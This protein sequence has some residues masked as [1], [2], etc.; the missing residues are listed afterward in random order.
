MNVI[1]II[2]AFTLMMSVCYADDTLYCVQVARCVKLE[3]A[4]SV[5]NGLKKYKNK[6]IEKVKGVYEVTVGTYRVKESALPL[7]KQLKAIYS[8]A[9]IRPYA[10]ANPGTVQTKKITGQEE[11]KPALIPPAPITKE[12][13]NPK[14]QSSTVPASANKQEIQKIAPPELEN[15]FKKG[16]QNFRNQQYGPA[17]GLLSQYVS[18]SPGSKQCSAALFAMAKSLEAMG[19][20]LS[21]LGTFGRILDQYPQSPEAILSIIFMADIAVA[22][23]GLHYPVFKGGS[24]YVQDP[25]LAYDTVLTK[26][27]PVP[28]VEEILLRKGRAFWKKGHCRESYETFATLLR[29]F[30]NTSYRK[31]IAGTSKACVVILVDQYYKAGDHVAAVNLFLESKEKGL[32][33]MD[34]AE[35]IL[36]SSLSLAHIGLYDDSVHLVQTVKANVRG[37]ESSDIDNTLSE[38]NNIKM[39]NGSRQLQ[40]DTKWGL[41][42]SGRD[43][44]N[45]NNLPLAE[46]TLGK[47]KADG[48]EAFWGKISDYALEDKRWSQKNRGR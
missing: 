8:D 16:M 7:L 17:V 29:E 37:K 44:L 36:K 30:R 35:T 11:K 27:I 23:P 13:S 47:L 28:M 6:R 22:N 40:P 18:L 9:Y 25:I 32:I 5:Y 42:Q 10:K 4:V 48:G 39:A 1:R 33:T 43:Y 31:E 46:Q 26:K 41:F 20:P 19:Q 45:S 2:I 15:Y 38:I 12:R 34:D 24:E 21:A 14:Q 3:N